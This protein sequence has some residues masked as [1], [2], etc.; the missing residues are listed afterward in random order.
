MQAA[1]KL[2]RQLN[3]V[4]AHSLTLSHQLLHHQMCSVLALFLPSAIRKRPVSATSSPAI[5]KTTSSN[6]PP[7]PAVPPN[8]SYRHA[9]GPLI[10]M[11]NT[12]IQRTQSRT[13]TRRPSFAIPRV[14]E[15]ISRG[16]GKDKKDKAAFSL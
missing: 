11:C 6:S 3:M 4:I 15:N 16:G 12:P 7:R 14:D 9:A 13:S 8:M 1:H 2:Q 10:S 5:L